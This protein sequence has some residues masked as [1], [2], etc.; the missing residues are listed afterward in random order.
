MKVIMLGGTG[1]LGSEFKKIS[2]FILS[3]R[4]IDITNESELY[5]KLDVIQPEIIVLAA[6]ETNSVK[7]DENPISAL[8]TNIKGAVNVT[9]YC[10]ERN[11]RL[12]YISSD[13]VY[14]SKSDNHQ[15]DEPLKPFNL[16]AWTKLGGE[17]AVRAH[18]NSLIIRTSFGSIEYPYEFAY[19]NRFV[20]KD[21][22]DIIAPMIKDLVLSDEVGVINVGTNEKTLY[23]YAQQRNPKVKEI[24]QKEGQIFVMDITKLRKFYYKNI[25]ETVV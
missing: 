7:I 17:C 5:S 14:D 13:Y 19:G 24:F 10:V 15:E 2:N 11:V 6:A 3:G 12:V 4:E 8:E 23:E 20:S 9:K 18:K 22:V 21:Y 16:Y 1:L 25:N